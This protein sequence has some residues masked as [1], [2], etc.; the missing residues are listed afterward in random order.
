MKKLLLFDLDGTLADTQPLLF[1]IFTDALNEC[2]FSVTHKEVC[3]ISAGNNFSP[4]RGGFAP[5]DYLDRVP[6]NYGEIF[7]SNYDNYFIMAADRIYDGIRE[8]IDELKARGYTVVVLSNKPF[9][10]TYPIIAK[11]FGEDYFTLVEGGSD[12]FAKK[13]APDGILYVCQ[14]LGF[15]PADAYM[16]GDLPADYRAAKSSGANFIP[17]GW[18]YGVRELKNEGVT[19][20]AARPRDILDI[21]E[22]K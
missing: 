2:G 1:H 5:N 22:D 3:A 15:D 19:D 6:E 20:F 4:V 17:A 9:R 10:Y 14:T 12:K 11:A 8:T 21:I 7:W 13:P 16:I 18:G